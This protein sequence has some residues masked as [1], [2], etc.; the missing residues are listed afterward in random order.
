MMGNPPKK[1][2]VS[3]F[4]VTLPLELRWTGN[5]TDAEVCWRGQ[6]FISSVVTQYQQKS[7]LT[8]G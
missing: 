8:L 5:L 7:E 2:Q 6:K 4:V 3:E 1:I